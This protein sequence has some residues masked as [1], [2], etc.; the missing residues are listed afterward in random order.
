M[1]NQDV[2]CLNA[3]PH[4][5]RATVLSQLEVPNVGVKS[6]RVALPS[7]IR[8]F[9]GVFFSINNLGLKKS[10]DLAE[11]VISLL[12]HFFIHCDVLKFLL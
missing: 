6:C 9:K 10:L 2:L 8:A 4:S 1:G 11:D 3:F 5:Q 12:I 7:H